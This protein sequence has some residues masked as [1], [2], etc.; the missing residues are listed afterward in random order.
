MKLNFPE[1]F[2]K[3][4]QI[5]NLTKILPVVAMQFSTQT[6]GLLGGQIDKHD[7]NDSRFLQFCERA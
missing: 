2:S 5:S 1:S 4:T 3:N 6:E 7:K